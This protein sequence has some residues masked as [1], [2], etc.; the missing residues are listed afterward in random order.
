MASLPLAYGITLGSF[1]VLIGGWF[2]ASRFNSEH[3]LDGA[4]LWVPMI[5]YT[6]TY[7][8]GLSVWAAAKG[9][10]PAIGFLCGLFLGPAGALVLLLLENRKK[11]ETR[12]G[13]H[14]WGGGIEIPLG[15]AGLILVLTRLL[16]LVAAG[17][18]AAG[19]RDHEFL[20]GIIIGIAV[21]A[22]HVG[23]VV[24]IFGIFRNS[25]RVA[26]ICGVIAWLVFTF[27]FMPMR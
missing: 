17:L 8:A 14:R 26:G 6:I 11:T 22:P 19:F 15:T 25:G 13:E 9:R 21:L 4:G 7:V 1:V 5:L 23:L 12:R 10:S 3:I 20:L 24:S 18:A 16:L 27:L 2:I